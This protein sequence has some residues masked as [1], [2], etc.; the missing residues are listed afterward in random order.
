VVGVGRPGPVSGGGVRAREAAADGGSDVLGREARV[1]VGR[2]VLARELRGD[3]G[4]RRP[5]SGGAG[6]GGRRREVEDGGGKWRPVAGAVWVLGRRRPSSHERDE[7][8]GISG[9]CGWGSWCRA[10]PATVF[11]G[12]GLA[13]AEVRSPISASHSGMATRPFS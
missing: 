13:Q 9:R 2:G 8:M 7:E 1:D 3:V 4:R 12:D 10:G 5:C 6:G 11:C